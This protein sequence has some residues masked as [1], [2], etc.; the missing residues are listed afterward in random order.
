MP[1]QVAFLRAIN[2]GGHVVKMDRL[3]MLFEEAGLEGVETF[4]ASGNVMFDAPRGAPAPLE[5][6]IAK[7]LQEA[8]GYEVA[9]FVR[10]AKE[11]ARIVAHDPFAADGPARSLYVGMTTAEP[12]R[13][14]AA[15]LM[16]LS[17][18]DDLFHVHAAE[19]YWGRRGGFSDS[20]YTGAFLE[21]TLGM[22]I[23][24]RSINTIRRLSARMPA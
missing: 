10:D 18:D 13:D 20:R 17:G 22:P 12:S 9:T 21:R 16:A 5:R 7:H 1:R 19:I 11:L 15:R 23:T 6:R 4:I 8:L 2:V 24:M 3:R 14:A